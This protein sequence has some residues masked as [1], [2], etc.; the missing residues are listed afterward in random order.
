[1]KVLQIN[2]YFNYGSTG[3]IEKDINDYLTESGAETYIAYAWQTDFSKDATTSFFK[4]STYIERC[5]CA[6]VTRITGN[7]YGYA[8]FS[9]IKLK[10]YIKKINPDIVHIHCINGYDVNIYSLFNFL[11]KNRYK[12]VITE[13]A[14]FFHTGNCA[15]AFECNHWINGCHNCPRLYYAVKSK[16]F[17]S[18]KRNWNRLKK[19]FDGFSTAT[20][21]PVSDWLGERTKASEITKQLMIKTI[22]NGINTDCFRRYDSEEISDEIKACFTKRTLLFVT[23]SFY[24][25]VKGGKYILQLAEQL[26]KYN[27]I[28]IC[29]GDIDCKGL[30]N[31]KHIRFI[32]NRSDLAKYYSLAD[33]TLL[34][35]KKETFSMPVAESLCCG[36]PVVGFCAGGPE[37]I[38]IP[39]YSDF[40]EYGNIRLL[41]EAIEK[42]INTVTDKEKIAEIA[43]EKY[44]SRVMA[45]NYFNLYMELIEN[46]WN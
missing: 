23:S 24:S 44:S 43:K 6:L 2:P 21:V 46:G 7:R 33:L 14:E 32:E 31:V 39:E 4:Y 20:M 19:A 35:S 29:S 1:M 10:R 42:R 11:K 25:E 12:T 8:F 9:T 40:V 13:H 5:I 17:D 26:P 30:K 22:L 41:E 3:K 18:T 36:T 15:Y 38:A 34:T 28:I 45:R 27:F 37:S 16:V